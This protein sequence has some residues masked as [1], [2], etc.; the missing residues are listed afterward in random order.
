MAPA[1]RPLQMT[2]RAVNAPDGFGPSAIATAFYTILPR[3]APPLLEP[4]SGNYR[5]QVSGTVVCA[6][7][8]SAP[9]VEVNTTNEPSLTSNVLLSPFAFRLSVRNSQALMRIFAH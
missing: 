9:Y 8:G 3:A 1:A 4:G 5:S 6:T 7:A 2:L